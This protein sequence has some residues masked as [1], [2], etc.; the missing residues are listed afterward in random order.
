MQLVDTL[1]G[2]AFVLILGLLIASN[3]AALWLYGQR[4]D[5]AMDALNDVMVAEQVAIVIQLMDRLPAQQR[6]AVAGALSGSM[7]HVP[8]G[9]RAKL[10]TN[11]IGKPRAA[12]IGGVINALLERT[13][14]DR[15]QV[16][17][18]SEP[19]QLG[20]LGGEEVKQHAARPDDKNQFAEAVLSHASL[21]GRIQATTELSDGMNLTI[22]S[23]LMSVPHFSWPQLFPSLVALTL[24]ALVIA[25]WSLNRLTAPLRLLQGAAQ[26]LAADINAPELKES[27]PK[28]VRSATAAFNALQTHIQQLIADRTATAAAIAH[29]LGT[30]VTQMRL[31][32]FEVD[33]EEVK[34]RLLF[35]L[36]QMQRMI[37]GALDFTRL[38][39][40]TE[41]TENVDLNSIV[42]SVAGDL[43]DLGREIS[44]QC[45]APIT[46]AT[47]PILLRRA[48]M[49]LADNAVNYGKSAEICAVRR[50]G[51]IEIAIYDQGRGMSEVEWREAVLPFRRLNEDSEKSIGS[52]LGLTISRRIIEDLGGT[53][54]RTRNE[55]GY[56]GVLVCF[57]DQS[58]KAKLG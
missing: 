13:A 51:K 1:S 5:G 41:R 27:G 52:G 26:R 44:V 14:H 8:A 29:D 32:V 42:E 7:L 17:L 56:F 4:H 6:K 18:D 37:A 55:Q 45:D 11:E 25:F 38:D 10:A 24:S 54:Q 28:E 53:V 50:D 49:N 48:L 9:E 43:S 46:L 3:A 23:R 30:P 40:A 16:I 58:R 36:D 12:R 31:R 47:K 19:G 39:F 22:T 20:S 2:R 57:S 34:R 15:I 21:Q 33:D 35:D